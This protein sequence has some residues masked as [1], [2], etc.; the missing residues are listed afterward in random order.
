MIK[1]KKLNNDD[2]LGDNGVLIS[3]SHMHFITFRNEDTVWLLYAEAAVPGWLIYI[4]E[5]FLSTDPND[6]IPLTQEQRQFIRA[7]LEAA[8]PVMGTSLHIVNG[9]ETTSCP[10]AYRQSPNP[11]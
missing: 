6:T 7:N 2:Y 11:T 1:F 8:C 5:A 10:P 9:N 3:F 4:D